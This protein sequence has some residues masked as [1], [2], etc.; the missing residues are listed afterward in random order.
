MRFRAP[1]C[2]FQSR[3]A[4]VVTARADQARPAPPPHAGGAAVALFDG[5]SL[6]VAALQEAGCHRLALVGR[7]RHAHASAKTARTHAASATSSP[8]RHT[9]CST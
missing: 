2:W 5:K 9:I 1:I 3:A 4:L 7:R 6:T 8:A